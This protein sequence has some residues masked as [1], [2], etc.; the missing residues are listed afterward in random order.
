MHAQVTGPTT[1]SIGHR[2]KVA[3]G[4]VMFSQDLWVVRHTRSISTA[5]YTRYFVQVRVKYGFIG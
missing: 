3:V 4:R 2:F 1:D 5:L